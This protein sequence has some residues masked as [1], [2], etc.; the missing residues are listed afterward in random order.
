MSGRADK[1]R[2]KCIGPLDS[3]SFE[4]LSLP[5]P[6]VGP[7]VPPVFETRSAK[8]RYESTHDRGDKILVNRLERIHPPCRNPAFILP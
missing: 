3:H 2:G 7:N 8:A 6:F 1:Y 4:A 5:A